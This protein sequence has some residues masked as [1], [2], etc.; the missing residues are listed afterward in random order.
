MRPLRRVPRTPM[1]D[2]GGGRDFTPGDDPRR[3]H[4]T[5]GRSGRP[6]VEFR[7]LCRELSDNPKTLRNVRAVLGNP[8][9]P[10]FAKLWQTV[11]EFGHGKA[12]Q[13]VEM[14]GTPPEIRVVFE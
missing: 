10:Q 9:H 3:G 6:T 1:N 13:A 8:D 14:T 4:G 11:S 5:K 12:L 2:R 7:A